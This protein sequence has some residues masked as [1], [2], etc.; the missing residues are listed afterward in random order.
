MFSVVKSAQTHDGSFDSMDLRH[1]QEQEMGTQ[2]K[3]FFF[4]QVTQQSE[5]VQIGLTTKPILSQVE[6]ELFWWNEKNW[7]PLETAKLP[8]LDVMIRLQV[9]P[10]TCMTASLFVSVKVVSKNFSGELHIELV[11]A[12]CH[13]FRQAE[14]EQ[15]GGWKGWW[16][17]RYQSFKDKVR[18]LLRNGY[19]EDSRIDCVWKRGWKCTEVWTKLEV[20]NKCFVGLF[21]EKRNIFFIL[22]RAR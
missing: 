11:S 12:P 20:V 3:E 18:V 22:G 15:Y 10:I 6:T 7:T 16:N 5:I 1:N 2:W 17:P 14:Q 19:H 21:G 8:V 9:H 13:V 4:G